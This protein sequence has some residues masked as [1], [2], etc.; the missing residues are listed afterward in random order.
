MATP[1]SPIP[2]DGLHGPE[3]LSSQDVLQHKARMTARKDRNRVDPRTWAPSIFQDIYINTLEE[4]WRRILQEVESRLFARGEQQLTINRN[5]GIFSS[6]LTTTD[7]QGNWLTPGQEAQLLVCDHV[8]PAVQTLLTQLVAS[9]PDYQAKPLNDTNE[10]AAMARI[11][12]EFID[13]DNKLNAKP[14]IR[15]QEALYGL[16]TG[17]TI[18][19]TW[20]DPKAGGEISVPDYEVLQIDATTLYE[21]AN[22]QTTGDIKDLAQGDQ[23]PE[24]ANINGQNLVNAQCPDCKSNV[25]MAHDIP[26]GQMQR[27]T[28]TSHSEDVGM[29]KSRLRDPG[30]IAVRVGA[31]D[32][33]DSTF[34]YEESTEE[35]CVLEAAFKWADIPSEP[36][37]QTLNAL[38]QLQRSTGANSLPAWAGVGPAT[39]T[40]P[41]EKIRFERLWLDYVA[42]CDVT[43]DRDTIVGDPE[44]PTMIIKA[45]VKLGQLFPDGLR[46]YKVGQT[47]LNWANESKNTRWDHCQYIKN[48]DGFFGD[49]KVEKIVQ[50]QKRRNVI[51]TMMMKSVTDDSV[52]TTVAKRSDIDLNKQYN[53][54]GRNMLYLEDT[55]TGDDVSKSIFIIPG[56]ELAK[57]APEM[58][59]NLDEQ[60]EFI[61]GATP[62]LRGEHDTGVHTAAEAGMQRAQA[63][64][65]LGPP[66]D[67]RAEAH[68]SRL[69]KVLNHHKKF[70]VKGQHKFLGKY[71]NYELECF[72]DP[73]NKLET[74]IEITYTQGSHIPKTEA[75]RLIQ[76]QTI[77]QFGNVPGGLFNRQFFADPKERRKLIEANGNPYEIDE[78]E[79]DWRNGEKRLQALKRMILI[80]LPTTGYDIQ[81]PMPDPM[82]Q[83]GPPGPDGQPQPIPSN[84]EYLKFQALLQAA[85][86][87]IPFQEIT[88]THEIFVEFYTGEMKTDEFEDGPALLVQGLLALLGRHQTIID[89]RQQAAQDA[90][91]K[92]QMMTLAGPAMLESIKSDTTLDASR[93]AHAAQLQKVAAEQ[94]HK[95]AQQQAQH[96]HEAVQSEAQRQHDA[97]MA[98]QQHDHEAE[99]QENEPEPSAGGGQ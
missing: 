44:E 51:D 7:D 46:M 24:V 17:D 91:A 12:Q 76:L 65:L 9:N 29:P 83:P 31:T 97:M 32:I 10:A 98:Q 16:E 23:V 14:S 11:A 77:A 3:M 2:A 86:S 19:E 39:Q 68:C 75:D 99:M 56:Q 13:L 60:A 82:M 42:Y 27:E 64:G 59:A 54:P 20:Y 88:D 95:A 79:P 50:V 49:G 30:G 15:Q 25:L 26:A 67:L 70:P 85:V 38:Y 34:L 94:S 93:I 21:C 35:R 55:F 22:C 8:H 61:T 5:T 71:Q 87:K 84:P 47:V 6:I 33:A 18:W 43:F 90:Q 57:S 62:P 81:Q 74:M 45:G 1:T 53:M 89:Q 73:A 28:G 63:A 80:E 52:Q 40:G 48:L 36:P 58:V 72:Y 78:M 69:M 37:S 4:R 92:Q 66:S 96:G 41:F